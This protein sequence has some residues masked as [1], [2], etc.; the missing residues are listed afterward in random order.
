VNVSNGTG[1]GIVV[2]HFGN[3]TAAH[4]A[5][6]KT[7]YVPVVSES[8]WVCVASSVTNVSGIEEELENDCSNGEWVQPPKIRI[9]GIWYYMINS[10][11]TDQVNGTSAVEYDGAKLIIWDE[12]DESGGIKYVGDPVMFYANYTNLTSGVPVTGEC[13]IS[14]DNA[15][16]YPMQYNAS[17]TGIYNY[18]TNALSLGTHIWNVRCYNSTYFASGA[19]TANDSIYITGN[20]T[21]APEQPY[22]YENILFNA[23]SLAGGGNVTPYSWDFGDGNNA[24]GVVVIHNYT[25][26]GTYNV[27]LTITDNNETNNI[28]KSITVLN[29]APFANAGADRF[30]YTLQNVNFSAS[31]SDDMDGNIISYLWDFNDT[32][33]GTG[34][35]VNHTY[36]ICGVYNV[37]LD[38]TDDDNT[39]GTDNLMLTVYLAGDVTR[40]NVVD[41]F[42]LAKFVVAWNTNVG[43]PKYNADADF[44]SD[45][46]ITLVDFLRL[47]DNWE[48]SC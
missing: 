38:V 41:V 26:N 1:K 47:V 45:G 7:I 3:E 10:S 13:N 43:D 39:H 8:G 46:H 42:D 29:R 17:G 12:I 20:F 14:F 5:G 27:T 2:I 33:T 40:S 9:N 31:D 24:S 28:S 25:D 36:V 6:S 21:Y 30:A 35:F 15:N 48:E 32:I 18:S 19:I 44:D 37:T 23:S 16:W 4:K 22:T 11:M 34:E